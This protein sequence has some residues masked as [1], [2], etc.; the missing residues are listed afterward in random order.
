MKWSIPIPSQLIVVSMG[1]DVCD[2]GEYRLY[3]NESECS[4]KYAGHPLK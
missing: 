1:I 2:R 3:Y 4:K